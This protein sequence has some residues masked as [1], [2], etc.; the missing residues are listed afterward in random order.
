M[1]N[2]QTIFGQL[3]ANQLKT[4]KDGVKEMSVHFSRIDDEKLAL[5]DI[6]S[7]IHDETKV[8]KKIINRIAKSYHKNSFADE[9]TQDSE[10][11]TLYTTVIGTN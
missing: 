5:K 7:S 6:V 9:V 2:I 11:E 4:I 8:S 1:T 3:D 10:F